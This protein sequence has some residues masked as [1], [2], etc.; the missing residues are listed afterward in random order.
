MVAIYINVTGN[1]Q[2]ELLKNCIKKF[3]GESLQNLK[4]LCR[5][6]NKHHFDRLA[7]LLKE[8]GVSASIVYGGS[9]DEEN[10]W[11]LSLFHPSGLVVKLLA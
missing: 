9:L 8:P 3:Y 1:F 10:L 2:V 7:N 5:I 6:V 11:V 4:N